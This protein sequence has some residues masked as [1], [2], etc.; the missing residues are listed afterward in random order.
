MSAL[1]LGGFILLP[2]LFLSILKFMRILCENGE[3]FWAYYLIS[4]NS[5]TKIS[6]SPIQCCWFKLGLCCPQ[7]SW[8][9][10]VWSIQFGSLL[11]TERSGINSLV[12]GDGSTVVFYVFDNDD[13]VRSPH[14]SYDDVIRRY[15][16]KVSRVLS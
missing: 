6:I 4:N 11:D 2:G 15:K 5:L 16:M 10:S 7:C 8:P 3:F 13:V 14:R 12:Y 1:L 9:F